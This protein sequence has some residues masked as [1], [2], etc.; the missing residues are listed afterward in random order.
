MK[1]IKKNDSQNRK[2]ST[3]AASNAFSDKFEMPVQNLINENAL[4]ENIQDEVFDSIVRQTKVLEQ[5]YAEK[6][7]NMNKINY[8]LRR[9]CMQEISILRETYF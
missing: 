3:Q 4:F 8:E 2:E 7:S 9:S 1:R 5:N 6:L